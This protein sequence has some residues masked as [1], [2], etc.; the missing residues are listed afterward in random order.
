[1]GLTNIVAHV[2][3]MLHSRIAALC[4]DIERGSY[5]IVPSFVFYEF[6]NLK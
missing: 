4:K 2:T 6:I 3:I 5:L 1:M